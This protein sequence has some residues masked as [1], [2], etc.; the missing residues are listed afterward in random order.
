LIRY[1][2]RRLV[3][4]IPIL[5]VI[6]FLAFS[7]LVAVPGDPSDV[8]I[9]GDP[10][11]SRESINDLRKIYGLD[12]PV[13]MRYVKWISQVA[14]GNFGY[15]R[16]FHLPVLEVVSPM[17]VNTAILTSLSLLT[18]LLISIPLGIYS[19]VK[20][21]SIGDYLGTS[22]A[23]FGFSVPSFWLALVLIIVFSVNL[24][25]LPPGG[26]MSTGVAPGL[27]DQLLDR[28]QYLIMPAFVLGLAQM[29]SWTRY[30]RSSLV[31]VIRQDYIQTARAK[32]LAERV[33]V[34]RHALKN[35]MIPIVTLIALSIPEMFSGAIV[36]ETVFS[37]PGMGRLYYQSI[38]NKDFS[39]V[40]AV[41]MMIAL[42]VI[43]SNLAADVFY[44]FL[45]PR[46]RYD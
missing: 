15:S 29:A 4:M 25:L 24:H 31:E 27:M 36:I 19:A 11:V 10:S 2:T 46:I 40:M 16:T 14:Q 38:F 32:G 35:A 6:S 45:D 7:L 1:I 30:M 28:A 34:Y 5:V 42:L 18:A 21:Y 3:E 22:F 20:Q 37:Y 33:V 23:F 41:L 12:D 13:P 8:L 44:A 43:L 39:V 9:L 26:M 17:L